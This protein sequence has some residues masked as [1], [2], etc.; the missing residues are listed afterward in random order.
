[1]SLN[2]SPAQTIRVNLIR[3]VAFAMLSFGPP[4]AAWAQNTAFGTNALNNNTTGNGNSAFGT[5]ALIS[6]TTGSANTA[7][8]GYTLYFNGTG[9]ANTAT[10]WAALEDNGAGAGNTATGTGALANNG[11]GNQNTGAGWNALY[12]NSGD[13]NT[14]IGAFA[15]QDNSSGANNIALGLEAG[16]YLTTGSNNIDIGNQ[17]VAGD[18]NSIRIGTAGAQTATY[19]AGIFG[20]NLTGG[21][22]VVV[23]STGQLGCVSSSARYKRDVRDMGDASDKL[24]KLRPVTFRYKADET[25]AQ[26][27]GLIAE[28][29]EKVYP[30]LVIH[31]TD[32]KVETVAYHMLP[33]MLLNEVQKQARANQQFARQLEQKDAQIA[34]L[35]RQVVAIQKR[36]AEIDTMAVRLEVLER[37]A[38][39]S[40]PIR[41]A[42]ASR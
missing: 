17:G 38:Q 23:G 35:Q 13:N 9:Y 26:Q 14:A 4:P 40:G 10:G 3:L 1:M 28:E 16:L 12:F 25:G 2:I 11:G 18:A 8:G 5:A 34:A 42:S 6:N 15:L 32:G 30:D 7:I 21:C 27:Y 29:V 19:L 41:L 20:V 31:G 39:A 37:Q 24:M 22:S 36:S 33:A